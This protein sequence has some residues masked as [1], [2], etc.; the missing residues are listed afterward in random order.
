MVEMDE[1]DREVMGQDRERSMS[2]DPDD[3]VAALFPCYPLRISY[4]YYHG[5][6]DLPCRHDNPLLR[7]RYQ[8]SL[9]H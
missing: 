7:L 3:D 4:F 5:I 6:R 8:L 1:A 9:I 2:A